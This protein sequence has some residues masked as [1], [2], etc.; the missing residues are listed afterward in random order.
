[1]IFPLLTQLFCIF[2]VLKRHALN[3]KIVSTFV[4]SYQHFIII[5]YHHSSLL[6]S[7]LLIIF[8][9]QLYKRFWVKTLL[10]RSLT[11]I[12]RY[13]EGI[14]DSAVIRYRVGENQYSGMFYRMH[15]N[16]KETRL[17]IWRVLT[18]MQNNFKQYHL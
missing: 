15:V 18:T 2:S 14:Y 16:Q 5:F 12:F 7:S 8:F 13:K 17:S 9:C 10:H 1:M 6:L 11:C 4:T 3:K